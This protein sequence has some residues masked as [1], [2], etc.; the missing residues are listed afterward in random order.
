MYSTKNL[1]RNNSYIDIDNN[2]LYKVDYNVEYLKVPILASVGYSFNKIRFNLIGGF[3]FDKII[4]YRVTTNYFYEESS[5]KNYHPKGI[6]ISVRGAIGIST[7]IFN[8]VYLNIYPFIDYK[9]DPDNISM[10]YIPHWGTNSIHDYYYDQIPNGDDFHSNNY[11]GLISIGLNV[12]FE[13]KF[14]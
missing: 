9:I 3:I 2:Y 14:H 8:N 13:Y 6:N 7:E 10:L 12:G 1:R 5:I 11:G 4:N